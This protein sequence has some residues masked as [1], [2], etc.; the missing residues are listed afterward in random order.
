MKSFGWVSGTAAPEKAK[1]P[2]LVTEA[3]AFAGAKLN[4][5]A[6]GSVETAGAAV[7]VAGKPNEGACC[8]AGVEP[9]SADDAFAPNLKAAV[10]PPANRLFGA[11]VVAVAA[12]PEKLNPDALALVAVVAATDSFFAL[13][14]EN[15]E[16]GFRAAVV[17][18]VGFDEKLKPPVVAAAAAVEVSAGV[19]IGKLRPRV[20]AAVAAEDAEK[21][22]PL[23]CAALALAAKLWSGTTVVFAG[24]V[25]NPNAV[26]REALAAVVVGVGFPEKLNSPV[27]VVAAGNRLGLLLAVV[28][29]ATAAVG[30]EEKLKPNGDDDDKTVGR[31]KPFTGV[32]V[33][34]FSAGLV[35]VAE[36]D[37][38][39]KLNPPLGFTAAGEV[40]L[41]EEGAVEKLNPLATVPVVEVVEYCPDG[42]VDV[43]PEEKL[44]P[45]L[46]FTAG[47]DCE[48][49]NPP[50]A[51]FMAVEVFSAGLVSEKLNPGGFVTDEDAVLVVGVFSTGFEV[52]A[53]EAEKL[54]PP[55]GLLAVVVAVV[56]I[57]RVGKLKTLVDVADGTADS[58][59]VPPR[60][61]LKPPVL[62]LAPVVV[63]TLSCGFAP[64]NDAK[65]N[66]PSDIVPVT[67]AVVDVVGVA[68]VDGAA[69]M[70][71]GEEKL[72]NEALTPRAGL[73]TAAAVVVTAAFPDVEGAVVGVDVVGDDAIAKPKLTPLPPPRVSLP[74]TLP[75]IGS[76]NLESKTIKIGMLTVSRGMI[77]VPLFVRGVGSSRDSRE[78][79]LEDQST[80]NN[81]TRHD[82]KLGNGEFCF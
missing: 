12:I 39:E 41:L 37:E 6:A 18:V 42:L 25:G 72:G 55:D 52:V 54:N 31:A 73:L 81:S 59:D 23:G 45:P 33:S 51:G 15:I 36:E 28:V 14:P 2:P 64:V 69:E 9:Q 47:A 53:T 78:R 57:V 30:F 61:K 66:P 24:A 79:N 77:G 63:V 4:P 46:G 8:F 70:A 48:K 43:T 10:D 60:E 22:N 82:G 16:L 3:G 7:V 58:T 27:V 50:T 49:L 32:V 56:A 20:V 17:V 29:L 67:A 71:D 76:V 75:V 74:P 40:S 44:N 13:K 1:P 62:Q 19:S 5:P 35:D 11:E 38:E 80:G 68:E 34:V 21:V 65:L 26:A